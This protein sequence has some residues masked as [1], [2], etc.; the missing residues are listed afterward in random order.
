MMLRS[1]KKLKK[2]SQGKTKLPQILKKQNK[3]K[4]MRL[5]LL[6]NNKCSRA[7]WKVTL[8]MQSPK[9]ISRKKIL[10][11]IME[12][13]RTALRKLAVLWIQLLKPQRSSPLE[14]QL[15]SS[16]IKLK[17]QSSKASSEIWI[18]ETTFCKVT[19][20]IKRKKINFNIFKMENC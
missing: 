18:F 20:Y 14:K 16:L 3:I 1:R 7:S 15:A 11:E 13:M 6:A 9:K 4:K 5:N 19:K 10:T 12:D 2:R 17:N 8:L